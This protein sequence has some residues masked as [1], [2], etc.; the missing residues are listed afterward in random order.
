MHPVNTLAVRIS[1]GLRSIRSRKPSSCAGQAYSSSAH[2]VCCSSRSDAQSG[3]AT[4]QAHRGKKRP[5][6][7]QTRARSPSSNGEV[8][9][10]STRY[11]YFALS[12]AP[13]LRT[14]RRHLE[15]ALIVL[16]TI[17]DDFLVPRQ[18]NTGIQSDITHSAS[19]GTVPLH[20]ALSHRH[21]HS[22]PSYD[23]RHRSNSPLVALQRTSG[24]RCNIHAH[25]CRWPSIIHQLC[26]SAEL[27]SPRA[28]STE[29]P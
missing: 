17:H 4:A 12:R 2:C 27:A 21:I 3:T 10:S 23:H 28:P 5:T 16:L 24:T 13:L 7:M 1:P 11:H 29:V 14:G 9:G 20:K 19:F 15:S 22:R 25:P 26:R 18:H 6:W 8:A